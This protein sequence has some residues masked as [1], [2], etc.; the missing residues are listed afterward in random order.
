MTNNEQ[1]LI[2]LI[3][4]NE[5]PEQALL[6]AV[7]IVSTFLGRYV[8]YQVPFADSQRELA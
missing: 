6:T 4:E 1:E 8:S 3:R 7:D 5:N 2:N